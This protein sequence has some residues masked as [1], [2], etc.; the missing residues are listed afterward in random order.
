MVLR[1]TQIYTPLPALPVTLHVGHFQWLLS[2]IITQTG[3]H[4]SI[5]RFVFDNST[6][7]RIRPPKYA[8][9]KN[10]PRPSFPVNP[11]Y[12]LANLV[13]V[14]Y[15][16]MPPSRPRNNRQSRDPRARRWCFTLFN[17]SWILPATWLERKIRGCV[18]QK[19]QCPETGRLHYQGYAEFTAPLR[20]RQ[21]QRAL[22]IGQANC[23]PAAGTAVENINY[24]TK[25][26]TRVPGTS[27]VQ[28]GA[29]AQG[30]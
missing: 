13:D 5:L 23:R 4:Q 11:T 2:I 18:Y 20:R 21:V 28:V 26:D 27:P 8:I 30:D 22:N 9:N 1:V 10:P 3:K 17:E 15:L 25:D 12:L 29:Y 24:C 14:D 16:T 7:P 6:N 19:E